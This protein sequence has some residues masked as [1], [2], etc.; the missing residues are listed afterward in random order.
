MYEDVYYMYEDVY[1]M[2]GDVY[3]DVYYGD[4]CMYNY[5]WG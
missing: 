3:G 2:Y 5:V 4:T 1:Y